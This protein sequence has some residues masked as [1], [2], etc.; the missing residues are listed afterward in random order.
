LDSD[1]SEQQKLVQVLRGIGDCLELIG[2]DTLTTFDHWAKLYLFLSMKHDIPMNEKPMHPRSF[3]DMVYKTKLLF[4]SLHRL[5]FAMIEGQKRCFATS[6]FLIGHVP[7]ATLRTHTSMQHYTFSPNIV[8]FIQR[9]LNLKDVR[10]EANELL[11]KFQVEVHP[12]YS[13]LLRDGDGLSPR[14][15]EFY[16]EFSRRLAAQNN[17]AQNRGW[18]TVLG[19]LLESE[20]FKSICLPYELYPKN[21]IGIGKAQTMKQWLHNYRLEIVEGILVDKNLNDI[22][23]AFSDVTKSKFAFSNFVAAKAIL[24]PKVPR[25]NELGIDMKR[26]PTNDKLLY[27]LMTMVSLCVTDPKHTREQFAKVLACEGKVASNRRY[28]EDL[29][30]TEKDWPAPFDQEVSLSMFLYLPS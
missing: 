21:S 5:R 2:A 27:V 28:A 12:Y 18:K 10:K 20:G 17:D 26:P 3:N 1:L 23:Q 4:H 30:P 24:D 8:T 19:N 6:L 11:A 29:I 7:S 14:V 15:M 22:N 13:E 25:L 9:D 16:R